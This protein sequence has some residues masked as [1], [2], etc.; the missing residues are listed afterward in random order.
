MGDFD[1][2]VKGG[3]IVS[4]SGV[5][6]RDIG[7]RNGEIAAI[8][9]RLNGGG[10]QLLDAAGMYVFPGGIDVHTHLA[11]AAGGTVSSDDFTTGTVAAACGGTTT[12][13]D[14]VT[15]NR[16]ESLA[17]AIAGRHRQALGRAVIDYGFH[18]SPTVIDEGTLAAIPSLIAD[19]YP[20]FKFYLTYDNLRVNDGELILALAKVRESGGL[21]CVHAENYYMIDYLVKQLRAAGKNAPRYHP[22]SRPPLVEGEATGRAIRLARLV[23]APIYIVHV[24]CG[25]SLAEIAGSRAEG[26]PVLGETCPQYLLLSGDRYDE[27]DFQAAK[28]VMSPP[29]RP[30]ENL[31]LLW[32]ALAGGQLQVVSTDH[33]PFNFHGQ[34]DLGRSFFGE[35]PNGA[36]GIEARLALLYSYGVCRKR[37]SIQRFVAV[38]ATNPARIFGLYPRKGTIAVGSDADLVVFDPNLELTITREILHEN[39]DYTPY[40]GMRL[41]GYPV[42]TIARGRIVAENGKFVGSIGSGK[43]LRRSQ[44]E[45]M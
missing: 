22:L 8:A 37:L 5:F 45:L 3:L 21:V 40:E 30:A 19:G 14:F 39:V 4:E 28:Y 13:I 6:A 32:D 17:E 20:S 26:V 42:A 23:G 10:G 36:P 38:T 34:K 41:Q 7:I 24:T 16:G 31:P 25:E 44:P 18:I 15:Q 11:T 27:P 33:C 1:L 2:V 12:I 43:F 35:I 29:L 9:G